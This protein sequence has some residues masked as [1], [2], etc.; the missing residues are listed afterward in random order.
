MLRLFE[1]VVSTINKIH[2]FSRG[3][4]PLPWAPAKALFEVVCITA[5]LPKKKSFGEGGIVSLSC[6]VLRCVSLCCF[7]LRCVSS[8]LRDRNHTSQNVLHM[9]AFSPS[10]L[11]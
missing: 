3:H 2:I 7:L 9:T 5:A 11:R 8:E 10:I 4:A 1:I 6:V